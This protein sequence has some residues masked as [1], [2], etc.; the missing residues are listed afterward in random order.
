[1][2]VLY[3]A[4]DQ[5]GA[6]KTALCS[7]LAQSL[8]QRGNA[9]A[10]FK[11]LAAAG[12]GGAQDPDAD[13]YVKL[14]DRPVEGWPLDSSEKGLTSELLSEV[15]SQFGRLAGGADVVLV[16]GSCALSS[17]E[18]KTLVGALD[19]SVVVVVRYDRELST[20]RLK[21]WRASLG[22]RLAGFVVNGVTRYAGAEANATVLQ[23]VE[24]EG[25]PLLGMT[26]EDRRLLG[27]SVGTIK[28][29]LDGRLI[30]DDCDDDSLVEHFMT[31]GL[32]M[33]PGELYFGLRE[34]KAVIVR[35]DRPDIQMSALATPTAC[36][37]CTKGIEPIEYVQYEA[38]QEEVP[39][40][41]VQSDTIATMDALND[42]MSR[43]R[44]DHPL[45]LFRFVELLERH[46]DL[47]ALFQRLGL[48]G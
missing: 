22:D 42:L 46:V 36:M 1:M 32:T 33:D 37:V 28:A 23:A 19:A 5:E 40:I 35:G 25:L 39:L 20:S 29:H 48:K 13:A 15:E 17:D 44:F 38:K 31:L 45:K 18:T 3:V 4:S 26:P 8:E 16:E 41:I 11:P 9:V 7:A 24:S 27:V 10:V 2:V 43:T 21:P 30:S 14:L 34:N 47:P 12:L 6:G